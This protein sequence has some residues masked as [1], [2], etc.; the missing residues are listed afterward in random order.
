MQGASDE[1]RSLT[2]TRGRARG[3][4]RGSGTGTRA[5][6]RSCGA[7]STRTARAPSSRAFCAP[8]ATTD[9][10]GTRS[11]GTTRSRWRGGCSTTSNRGAA[12]MTSTIQPPL[13]AWAWRI[14]VGDPAAEPRSSAHHRW[15]R[16]NRDLEGD[17]LLWLVQPDES[18]LDSSPKFDP[19]WGRRAHG[20]AGLPTAGRPQPAARL[21]RAPGPRRRRPRALRG[22]DQ[23]ALGA[24]APGDGR[25]LDHARAGRSPLGRA[26][27]DFC[28]EAR[29]TRSGRPCCGPAVET[30]AALAPLAL[31]DLP[32][33]IGRRLVEEHLLDR[34][35]FWLP[36]APPSVSAGEPS[37]EPGNGRGL[38]SP[39]LARADLGQRRVAS[40]DRD[41]PPRLPRPGR[42]DGRGD[43][44]RRSSA[45]AFASTT[46]HAPAPAWAPPT[47]PG[48]P[49]PSR[50]PTR[51]PPPPAAT[52]SAP[53]RPGRVASNRRTQ[54]APGGTR[55]LSG[56]DCVRLRPHAAAAG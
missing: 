39:L 33:A 12:E 13:L 8:A 25:A 51:T 18:G 55:R 11:S 46:T 50:W 37:F 24:V 40:V 17:G 54:V 35:R 3:D 41:E 52:S 26:A 1:R 42:A 49:S 38:V 44:A 23:R 16:D 28:D 5:L 45:R 22:G 27:R 14:A 20:E 48:P 56:A 43:H 36:V 31:P 29:G 15:L 10:S 30:W 47:S 9:S 6:R 34:E 4:T 32:E 7:A 2:P 21:G 19:V 53:H